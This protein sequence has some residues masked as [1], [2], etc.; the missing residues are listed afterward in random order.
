MTA[1]LVGLLAAVGACLRLAVDTG[2][3]RWLPS[4]VGAG[5]FVVNVTGSFA[6]GVVWAAAVQ[7]RLDDTAATVLGAGLC[8]GYTTW[9]TWAWDTLSLVEDAAY[10]RALLYALASLGAGVL[11][12]HA[13]L[14][15]ALG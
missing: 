13:G 11:A 2:V 4:A 15:V 1:V 14:A 5:T 12:A 6:L 10:G 7:A 3:R 9:S 8:G